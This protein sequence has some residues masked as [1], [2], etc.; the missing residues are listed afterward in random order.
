M[1]LLRDYKWPTVGYLSWTRRVILSHTPDTSRH[2]QETITDA[3]EKHQIS[4]RIS[5]LLKIAKQ[6]KQKPNTR[7]IGTCDRLNI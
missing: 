5:I 2:A 4:S 7:L 1:Q 6:F 3:Q